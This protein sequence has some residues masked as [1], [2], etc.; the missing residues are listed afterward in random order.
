VRFRALLFAGLPRAFHDWFLCRR[1]RGAP[2]SPVFPVPRLF[3]GSDPAS[4]EGNH[5]A[6]TIFG[7][8]PRKGK[9]CQVWPVFTVANSLVRPRSFLLSLPNVFFSHLHPETSPRGDSLV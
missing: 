8:V 9:D 3:R 7:Y 4:Q 5:G 6:Q 1:L 2:S